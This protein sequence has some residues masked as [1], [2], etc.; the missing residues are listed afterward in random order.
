L[1]QTSSTSRITMMRKMMMMIIQSSFSNLGYNE[2]LSCCGVKLPTICAKT[3]TCG[4]IFHTKN[5]VIQFDN[6]YQTT[7]K[8][9][10]CLKRELKILKK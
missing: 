8:Y 10:Q 1:C 4:G 7:K 5:S 9:S 2:R 3:I 6:H